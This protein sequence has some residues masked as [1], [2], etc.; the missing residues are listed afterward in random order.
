MSPPVARSATQAPRRP[1]ARDGAGPLAL[2]LALLIPFGA[3]AEAPRILRA[4]VWV[5][6]E[7]VPGSVAEE[8]PPPIENLRAVARFVMGGMVYGWKFTY[9]PSDR[10]RSVNEEFTLAPILEIDKNDS[11]LILDD[12]T[13]KYP[14]LSCWAQYTL[15]DSHA[16]WNKYWDSVLFAPSS[17][18][19][20]GERKDETDGIRTAYTRA[21][22]SA[23]RERA[24]KLEKNKPKEIV[25]EL[26]LR[27]EPR[28]FPDEG[29]FV[30]DVD[31]LINIKEIVPYTAF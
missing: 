20:S 2:L 25:G 11:R 16:R 26:L 4:P 21:L 19:G 3:F 12:I 1:A 30:A 5:Y 7:T 29:R 28:L 8:I 13:P 23:V 10:A 27:D 9:T 18:R 31:V 14:K 17:G 24:R 22:L 6:L 15:D